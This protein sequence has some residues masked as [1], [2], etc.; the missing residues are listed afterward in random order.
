MTSLYTHRACP[1]TCPLCTQPG[2]AVPDWSAARGHA[3]CFSRARRRDA[4]TPRLKTH[5]ANTDPSPPR[6]LTSS[7]ARSVVAPS[8][9]PSRELRRATETEE[10]RGCPSV[11]SKQQ[12]H[13][14]APFSLPPRH[15][16]RTGSDDPLRAPLP[17]AAAPFPASGFCDPKSSSAP[18]TATMS[19]R[20]WRCC[21]RCFLPSGRLTTSHDHLLAAVFSGGGGRPVQSACGDIQ[22]GMRKEDRRSTGGTR[23]AENRSHTLP[24]SAA[25]VHSTLERFL[26]M[27]C[28][29][30]PLRASF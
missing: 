30:P 21:R 20:F 16:A 3:R 25:F 7:V 14:I 4:D 19:R 23:A 27:P 8:L 22:G 26:C 5:V 1:P 11:T 9:R 24:P 13:K 2:A 18:P 6:L 28:C 15:E 29:E 17:T 10:Q 12:Q